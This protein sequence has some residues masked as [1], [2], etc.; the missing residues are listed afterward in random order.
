MKIK[1]SMKLIASFL[2]VLLITAFIGVLGLKQ[3]G[4]I[5]DNSEDIS[6]NW[7]RKTRLL[8]EMNDRNAE[9]R[10]YVVQYVLAALRGDQ[11]GAAEFER[12]IEPAI[13]AFEEIYPEMEPLI[14]TGTG[15]KMFGNIKTA[16]NELKEVD[17][18]VINLVKTGNNPGAVALLL[19][20]SRN[21]YDESNKT[22]IDF[23]N[24]NKQEADKLTS[25]NQA[26]YEAGRTTIIIVIVTALVLG[27]C[28]AVYI[29]RGISKPAAMLAQTALRVADGDLTVDELRVKSRDEIRDVADSFN[30]MID[31]LKDMIHRISSTSQSVAATSEE[32]S[33]NAE[34]ATK[35][36]RQVA[37][38]IEQVAK[39][40]GEQTRSVTDTAKV[41]EQVAQAIEQ[42]AAGAQ[43]Q[44]KNVT[45]TTDMVNDMV[46]KIDAMAQGMETVK[47]V[48][49]QN[50]VV[51]V[52]GGKSVEKTVE[53]ML[54]VK[55]AV[56][57]TARRINEL[58]EQSQKIGEIIQVIDDIAEQ[59]NLLA[60]NAAIEAARAGEHGK[61]FA[62]VAD[63]VRRLAERSGK[64]TKEIADLITDI[65]RG[66][67][68]AVESMQVGTKEVEEGVV[69][70][71]E[72]GK[73]LNEI[74]EGVKIAGEHVSKIMGLIRDILK[75]SEEVSKAVNNVAAITEENTAATEEMSASA[76]QVN[77]AM[78]NIASI[79]EESAASAEEV[80]AS[81]EEL[82]A[83]IEEISASSEQ[84]ARMA[85]ELQE[86][87]A[88]FRV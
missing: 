55:N 4:Q 23:I 88:Q 22:L 37:G 45:A 71:Q 19:G 85:R 14:V 27:L 56:F 10:L 34:E 21:K 80:S 69:L 66:T 79:S 40:S 8:G 29:A 59:T 9:Y 15:K 25:E 86:L 32:L 84:L 44:S 72:A 70:A 39:G 33:S 36:T 83:S 78:Q 67:G 49:E 61:G 38:A 53:G 16:W 43:E 2:V 81:T 13:K 77:A 87:V 58:G 82:T 65:Q 73:S 76:E 52:E 1:I 26:A 11:A 12:K 20:E 62:V 30:K 75:S 42:I 35:A 54:R 57:E 18:R 51:A 31:N 64:A 28:L 3:A 60:L 24:F 68:V 5:N 6:K 7:L 63:E 48:A 47:Q 46:G 74:V 17:K 50:G 41:V